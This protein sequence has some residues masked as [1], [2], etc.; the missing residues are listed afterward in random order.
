MNK[1][2]GYE[3]Y[4]HLFYHFIQWNLDIVDKFNILEGFYYIKVSLFLQVECFN[5][6]ILIFHDILSKFRQKKVIYGDRAPLFHII[7]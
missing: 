2:K 1:F 6:L 3:K 7:S 4:H 5:A